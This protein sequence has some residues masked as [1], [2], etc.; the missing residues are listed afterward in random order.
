MT[1]VVSSAVKRVKTPTKTAGAGAGKSPKGKKSTAEISGKISG[2]SGGR[3]SGK[4][5][6]GE[7]VANLPLTGD[8]DSDI[9][10]GAEIEAAVKGWRLER[11]SNGYFRYRWQKKDAEGN[12]IKYVRESGSV[13]YK[14][15]S[16]Y[17]PI[18][19]A[20]EKIATGD[21]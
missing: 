11:N 7:L 20:R 6:A 2:K 4:S 14:R 19:I 18:E 3:A 21:V 13:G 15:G 5:G 10:L 17:V 12:P 16:K 1:A 9:E 8:D